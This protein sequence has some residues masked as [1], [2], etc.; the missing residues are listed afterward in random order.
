MQVMQ[1]NDQNNNKWKSVEYQMS[2][3]DQQNKV[4]GGEGRIQTWMLTVV[5][6]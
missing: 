4:K 2:G 6:L 1:M 3:G 5:D